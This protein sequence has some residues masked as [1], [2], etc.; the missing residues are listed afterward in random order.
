[1]SNAKLI[2]ENKEYDYMPASESLQMKIIPIYKS[3][4]GWKPV[5]QLNTANSILAGS[6]PAP[7]FKV[8]FTD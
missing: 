1:M 7:A 5:A 6:A 4:E 2:L 3:L 8:L